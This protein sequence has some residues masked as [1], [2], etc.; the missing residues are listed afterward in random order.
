MTGLRHWLPLLL[1][2]ALAGCASILVPDST[3]LTPALINPPDAPTISQGGY[4]YESLTSDRDM[5]DWLILVALSG[6]GKRSAAFSHGALQAMRDIPIMTRTGPDTLLNQVDVISGISGGGFTAAYYGLHRDASF[7]RYETDFLYHD[8][9]AAILR[10]YMLPW[11]WTW[12][13]DPSVG[14]NDFMARVY[15]ET[16][17]HGRTYR[18]LAR[19]G[20]PLIL[21]GATDISY[22]RPFAFTQEYFDLICAD[23][24]ALPISRAVAASNGLPGLF[25]PIT[26]TSHRALCAGREPAWLRH[27]PA[28]VRRDPLSRLGEQARAVEV[29]LDADRT[30]YVHL[31][32]GGITDNLGL[33]VAG[34]MIQ[35]LSATPDL[36]R[37]QGIGRVRRI[38]LIS[39]DGQGA[40]DSAVARSRM[41]GGLLSLFGLVSGAQIDRYNF[42]TLTAVTQQL[43]DAE[44]GLRQARC[45]RARVIDGARCDD[46]LA[47][48]VHVSLAGMPDGPTKDGLLAIPTG[49][50]IPRVDVDALVAAGRAAIRESEAL[51]STIQLLDQAP[52]PRRTSVS[53][54]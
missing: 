10:I 50:T 34:G 4:R 2:L 16:M 46:V 45:A 32:D 54:R 29:Y 20:R 22:G 43:R 14:T 36:V 51:R 21:L 7:G 1:S 42:E 12:I 18:D 52:P 6:G 49:L 27:I 8:T 40:Q 9:N 19:L 48:L 24:E 39:V 53:S 37:P 17:F 31:A 13:T 3:P 15:D 38:L 5:D 47:R 44:T 35:A 33:R 26:L 30:R 25:S 11:N 41:V 28:A 23:L